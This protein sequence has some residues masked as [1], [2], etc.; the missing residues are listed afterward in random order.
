MPWFD[1]LHCVR[2][3]TVNPSA[4]ADWLIAR[5]Q[6][7]VTT[8]EVAEL[9]GVEPSVVSVSLLR[10]REASKIVSVTKGGWVPVPPEY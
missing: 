4:L 7:F 9:V 3:A 6:H 2:T 8:D 10:A 5:G 1:V